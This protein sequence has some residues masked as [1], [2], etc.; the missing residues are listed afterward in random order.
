MVQVKNDASDNEQQRKQQQEKIES[1]C[2]DISR[3]WIEK[4][5]RCQVTLKLRSINYHT[6]TN[7]Q[8]RM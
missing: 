5:K 4:V 3:K 1:C 2:F 6:A 7:L 8:R